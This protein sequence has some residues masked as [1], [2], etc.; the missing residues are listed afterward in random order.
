MLARTSWD[1]NLHAELRVTTPWQASD[2]FRNELHCAEPSAAAF[3][4]TD[5]D[6]ARLPACRALN[7]AP[8]RRHSD[9]NAVLYARRYRIGHPQGFTELQN[10]STV[11]SYCIRE[12]NR[13]Y[14]D[15]HSRCLS[16]AKT[17]KIQE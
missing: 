8:N 7:A 6:S 15:P 4:R 14:D 5:A 13:P 9:L 3:F 10:A 12:V 16:N 17:V 11:G 1:D 2:K